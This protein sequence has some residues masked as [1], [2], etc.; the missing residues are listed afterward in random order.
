[1]LL[2]RKFCHHLHSGWS[3]PQQKVQVS[4]KNENIHTC[5]LKGL[6]FQSQASGFLLL[7]QQQLMELKRWSTVGIPAPEAQQ[8]PKASL[9]ARHSDGPVLTEGELP[10]LELEQGKGHTLLLR[11]TDFLLFYFFLFPQTACKN[12]VQN[13]CEVKWEALYQPG[14]ALGRTSRQFSI[15]LVLEGH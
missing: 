2:L 13:V 7:E 3:L 8:T 5:C 4:L 1:M 14:K 11:K 10:S 6:S 9:G 15:I 12:I